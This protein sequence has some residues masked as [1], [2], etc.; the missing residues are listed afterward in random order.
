[1][2][3]EFE[4]FCIVGRSS[5]YVLFENELCSKGSYVDVDEYVG[6]IWGL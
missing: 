5:M 6:L 4:G 3:W 2:N 1:M